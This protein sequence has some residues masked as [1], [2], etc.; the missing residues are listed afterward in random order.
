M[1]PNVL[2]GTD[3]PMGTMQ[4]FD[5]SGNIILISDLI[6]Y[7]VYIYTIL[8]NIKTNHFVFKKNPVGI[9]GSIIIVDPN[10]IG[11][12][13]DRNMTKKIFPGIIYVEIDVK[14]TAS[15]DYI[16]SSQKVGMDGYPL[17]NIIQGAAPNIM[18]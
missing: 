18:N 12:I 4:F 8:N 3:S 16:S 7:N 9:D 1:I 11:W 10:T 5:I 13:V 17:A 6:D 14:L 2:Q 15:G